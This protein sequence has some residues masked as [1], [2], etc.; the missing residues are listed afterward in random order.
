VCFGHCEP[1]YAACYPP[2]LTID[3][4][5]RWCN[6]ASCFLQSVKALAR[7]LETYRQPIS[8]RCKR[9]VKCVR[10]T[11]FVVLTGIAQ[12]LYSSDI[13]FVITLWLTKCSVALLTL[14]L[15]P[16]K[17]HFATLNTI[18]FWFTILLAV[19]STFVIALRCN[20]AQPWIFIDP[21]CTTNLVRSFDV[22]ILL[23]A[24]HCLV[25]SMEGC[26]RVRYDH[27]IGPLFRHH[28]YRSRPSTVSFKEASG[29]CT[30]CASSLVSQAY[31][32]LC[33]SER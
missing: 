20:L 14:R 18:A 12:T 32:G 15:S 21:P 2:R 7:P 24:N 1:V 26:C 16:N 29:H 10:S 22:R 11:W 5:S 23:F 31:D 17:S 27:R 13:L 19:I 25:Y 9:Y 4:Y 30:L 6:P 8:Y 3:R 28:L 33:G